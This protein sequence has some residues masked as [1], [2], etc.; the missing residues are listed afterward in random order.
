MAEHGRIGRPGLPTKQKRPIP[1]ERS[2]CIYIR[3]SRRLNEVGCEPSQNARVELSAE[4]GAQHGENGRSNDWKEIGAPIERINAA[5]DGKAQFRDE[6]K[7]SLIQ[8][9]REKMI[10]LSTQS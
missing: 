10:N 8:P 1:K 5:L 4:V 6:T 3:T 9:L 2:K 7:I